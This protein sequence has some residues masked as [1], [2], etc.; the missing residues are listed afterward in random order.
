MYMLIYLS[1]SSGQDQV[2]PLPPYS[3][4]LVEAHVPPLAGQL[5]LFSRNLVELLKS[6]PGCRMSF[7]KFIPTF[8]LHFGVQCR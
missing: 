2:S 4:N 5:R 8:H 7:H 1:S 3:R 6:Q